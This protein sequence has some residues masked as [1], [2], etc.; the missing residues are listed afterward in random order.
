MKPVIQ[1]S[2]LLHLG[3]YCWYIVCRDWH[4]VCPDFQSP[5]NCT[6]PCLYLAMTLTAEK[7]YIYWKV[8]AEVRFL[9]LLCKNTYQ[10][11]AKEVIFPTP[12]HP[13]PAPHLQLELSQFLFSS[14]FSILLWR[15]FLFYCIKFHLFLKIIKFKWWL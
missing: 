12:H 8:T 1:R 4:P 7:T 5:L 15:I 14:S 11:K 10:N 13:L 6:Y 2:K 3:V 9:S